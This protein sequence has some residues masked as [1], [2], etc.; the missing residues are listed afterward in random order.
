MYAYITY[1]YL[2]IYLSIHL[3]IYVM[4]CNLLSL[5][6]TR[7]SVGRRGE[8]TG[9]G[10]DHRPAKGEPQRGSAQKVKSDL[11]VT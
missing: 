4:V 8:E 9:V 6:C 1:M 10:R 11:K 3:S 5:L 2:S 7:E